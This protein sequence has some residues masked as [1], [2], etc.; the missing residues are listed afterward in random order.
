MSITINTSTSTV[1]KKTIMI[2]LKIIAMI[3]V[4]MNMIISQ[5]KKK[6][7]IVK[8]IITTITVAKIIIMKVITT[9]M[10][11]SI[12]T[13]TNPMTMTIRII[14]TIM[15]ITVLSM[16]VLMITMKSTLMIMKMTIHTIA[17]LMETKKDIT[18]IL[19]VKLDL[20]TI[21]FNRL[22]K[23]VFLHI[24]ADALGSV[25]VIISSV[26]IYYYGWFISDPITSFIISIFIFISVFPLLK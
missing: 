26:L 13:L 15:P 9:I 8:I 19:Q 18:K 2:A 22:L 21:S 14:T 5:L 17:T 3:A 25:G 1:R 11:T 7:T 12:T 20:F 23:G 10:H 4:I 6:L 16:N 24:L